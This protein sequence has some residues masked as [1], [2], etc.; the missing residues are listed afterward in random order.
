VLWFL[1]LSMC[2]LC[3]VSAS[4]A[5]EWVRQYLL[6]TQLQYSPHRCACIRACITQDGFLKFVPLFLNI[7]NFLLHTSIYLFFL[8]LVLLAIDPGDVSLHVGGTFSLIF[9]SDLYLHCS[10]KSIHRPYSLIVTPLSLIWRRA[11]GVQPPGWETLHCTARE[12][13]KHANSRTST[14]D[15]G[16]ISW[17]LDS[18]AHAE[19]LEQFLT[20]IPGFYKSTW[21]EDP[22]QVLRGANTDTFPEAIVAFMNHSLSSNLLSDTTRQQ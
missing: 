13:E 11:F 20:G 15:T 18:L 1:S 19:E 8:G 14:L 10:G 17:L 3:A 12:V 2:L 7:L 9:S 22:A 21:V 6:L 16:A 4:L 5:Q